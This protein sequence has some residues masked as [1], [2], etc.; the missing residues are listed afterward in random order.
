MLQNILSAANEKTE[1]AIIRQTLLSENNILRLSRDNKGHHMIILIIKKYNEGIKL[2]LFNYIMA[3]FRLLARDKNGLCVMKEIIQYAITDP[4][5]LYT[6]PS[7]RDR[8]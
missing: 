2:E 5:L 1:L 3:N 7:P 4:C 6:S 8:G